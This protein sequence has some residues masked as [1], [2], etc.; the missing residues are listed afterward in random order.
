MLKYNRVGVTIRVDWAM[1]LPES[2]TQEEEGSQLSL[3][4]LASNLPKQNQQKC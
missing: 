4:T 2:S 3:S 1:P